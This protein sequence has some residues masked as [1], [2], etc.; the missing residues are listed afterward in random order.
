MA[1]IHKNLLDLVGNTPLVE[2]ERIA[3]ARGAEAQ[4]VAKV[5]Y[6]NPIGSIKDRIVLR[7]IEDA[8]KEGKII[9]GKKKLLQ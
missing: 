7:I 2:I 1:N 9:P 4:V 8:E 6:F 5:E 3:K